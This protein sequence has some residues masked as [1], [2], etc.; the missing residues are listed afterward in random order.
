MSSD[1]SVSF[2]GVTKKFS[3][4]SKHYGTLRENIMGYFSFGRKKQGRI[5][6]KDEFLALDRASFRIYQGESIGLYGP[7][8]SGKSTILKLIAKVIFPTKGSIMVKGRIAPLIELGA[9][10]HPDLNGIEN[11]YMNG[12]ILG[13]TIGEIKSKLEKIIQFSEL[14]DFI[15]T[16]VKKYS[17]GMKLRLGFSIA[18]HSRAD[19]FL[20]DEILA[21]GD[22]DFK[23]KSLSA[24]KSLAKDNK[25]LL[26]VSHNLNGLAEMTDRIIY[27][28]KGKCSEQ[29]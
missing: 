14:E 15:S 23:K 12:A 28:Q 9:G 2:D 27:V 6:N 7:N 18:I 13:M 24:I 16:P 1:I 19:I 3:K 5:L 10:F 21:V 20:F 25:T 17:S 29:I 8:G 22:A 4:T 26:I 11:I